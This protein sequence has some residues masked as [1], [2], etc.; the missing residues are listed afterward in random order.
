LT[1]EQPETFPAAS[2]A[3]ARKLVFE[4]S[5]TAARKP[6]DANCVDVPWA[7][8]VPVQLVL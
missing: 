3:V 7:I 5:G 8:G 2:V 1:A 4:S 6:G